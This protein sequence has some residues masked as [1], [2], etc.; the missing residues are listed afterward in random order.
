MVGLIVVG[1]SDFP[2][3]LVSSVEEIV[4]HIEKL[5]VVP[6]Y[7]EESKND[8]RVKLKKT[9]KNLGNTDGILVLVDMF[10][11]T[12]C[13]VSISLQKTFRLKI[14]TGLNLPMLLEAVLHREEGI[15]KLIHIVKEAAKKSIVETW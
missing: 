1:H 15:E 14:I 13:N 4:G 10:G 7:P 2:S 11:G 9:I 3:V 12:P 5:R 8:L 6:L